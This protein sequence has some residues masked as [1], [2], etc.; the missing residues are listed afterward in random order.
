MHF[1]NKKKNAVQR[2]CFNVLEVLLHTFILVLLFSQFFRYYSERANTY[3][4][5]HVK[6]DNLFYKSCSCCILGQAEERAVLPH[7]WAHRCSWLAEVTVI[8][9]EDRLCYPSHSES[10]FAF[11]APRHRWLRQCWDLYLQSPDFR[12]NAFLLC[13]SEALVHLF[14]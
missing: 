2:K 9:R 12:A 5:W 11:L 1:F 10:K 13:L 7:A 14:I 4:L 8:D 6:P 3:F